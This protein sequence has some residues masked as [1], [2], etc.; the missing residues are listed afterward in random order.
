VTTLHRGDAVLMPQVRVSIPHL[1]IVATEP[2]VESGQAILAN[3]TNL[4]SDSDTTLVL[5]RSDHPFITKPSV[6]SFGDAPIADVRL[7]ASGN[8]PRQSPCSAALIQLI[9]AGILASSRTPQKVKAFYES[10][11]S[12]SR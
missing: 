3:L 9:E 8:F 6:I 7:V 4:R 12:R 10:I 1:W 5:N 11:S 2:L